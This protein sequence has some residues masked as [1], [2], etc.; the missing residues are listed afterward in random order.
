[1]PLPM[2]KN[3]GLHPGFLVKSN[4]MGKKIFLN[5]KRIIASKLRLRKSVKI[6]QTKVG[7]LAEIKGQ[8]KPHQEHASETVWFAHYLR[9]CWKSELQMFPLPLAKHPTF[10]GFWL[11]EIRSRAQLLA[12]SVSGKEADPALLPPAERTAYGHLL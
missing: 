10:Q 1:M 4:R 2:K 11:A 12:V 6:W 8:Q 3:K 9:C 7:K 5:N